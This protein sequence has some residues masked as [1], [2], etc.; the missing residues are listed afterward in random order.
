MIRKRDFEFEKAKEAEGACEA[1][2]A[3]KVGELLWEGEAEDG[4]WRLRL[5][6][7]LEISAPRLLEEE[8]AV[9]TGERKK[10][11]T[12]TI[13]KQAVVAARNSHFL[14][15]IGRGEQKLSRYP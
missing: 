6:E 1:G 3:G 7:L 13:K 9:I 8:V 10:N 2:E 11:Q 5:S 14:A 15:S 4:T 12:A